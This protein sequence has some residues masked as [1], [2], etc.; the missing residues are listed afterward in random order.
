MTNFDS[1]Y[2][3]FRINMLWA[4]FLCRCYKALI[5]F[6]HVSELSNKSNNQLYVLSVVGI[7]IHWQKNTIF[8]IDDTKEF[9]STVLDLSH[10]DNSCGTHT[11]KGQ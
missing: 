8:D 10:L 11:S 2:F 9:S 5:Q 1:F 3:H 7:S 6:T 4:K